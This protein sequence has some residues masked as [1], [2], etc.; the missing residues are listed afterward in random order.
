[1]GVL[2]LGAAG[3]AAMR[4]YAH[5]DYQAPYFTAAGTLNVVLI[6]AIAGAATGL[7][8]WLGRWLFA[9]PLHQQLFFWLGLAL[10][11]W[12]V[13][14]P[15][16]LQR[17]QVFAPLAAVHGAVLVLTT[18]HSSLSNP[19]SLSNHHSAI[20]T[21]QSASPSSGRRRCCRSAP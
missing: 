6:A 11:T 5:L 3:R 8:L 15:V 9:R 13:L 7:W 20:T 14:N 18:R 1:M 12:R 10:L 16:S 17:I 19:S 4:W 21:H 2:F